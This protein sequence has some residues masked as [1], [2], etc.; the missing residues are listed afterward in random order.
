MATSVLTSAEAMALCGIDNITIAP[1]LLADLAVKPL[2]GTMREDRDKALDLL[3]VYDAE[4][5]IDNADNEVYQNGEQRGP[6]TYDEEDV[7]DA[8]D[9]KGGWFDDQSMAGMKL[10][11]AYET[12][13]VKNMLED[14]LT[15]F[16]KAEGDLRDLVALKMVESGL[17]GM[18][19]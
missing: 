10:K 18:K 5:D 19:V 7:N 8:G 1:A 11:K 17:E 9:G 2:T 4:D 13:R 14:A 3:T 6:L 16:G 15:I 12:D